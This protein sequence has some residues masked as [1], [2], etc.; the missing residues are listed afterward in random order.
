MFVLVYITV[1]GLSGEDMLVLSLSAFRVCSFSEEMGETE[2]LG[3]PL[4]WVSFG[5]DGLVSCRG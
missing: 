2:G 3:G 1:H 4:N 5:E